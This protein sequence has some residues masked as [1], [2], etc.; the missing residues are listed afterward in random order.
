M[1]S[2]LDEMSQEAK[3]LSSRGQ[4]FIVIQLFTKKELTRSLL[5]AIVIQV[6]QQWSG[7]NAVSSVKTNKLY[8]I[9]LSIA[10][11]TQRR[12]CV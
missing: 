3:E 6:A 4:Q 9:L 11:C 1:Q 2:E 10:S 7:I 12:S 5:I 8:S